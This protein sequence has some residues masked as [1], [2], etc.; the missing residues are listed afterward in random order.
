MNVSR[1]VAGERA[2]MVIALDSPP[3]AHALDHL[4]ELDGI[5][6]VRSVEV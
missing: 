6:S 3:P 1:T 2:V 4:R 5:H